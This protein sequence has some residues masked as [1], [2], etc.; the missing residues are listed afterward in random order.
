MQIRIM[1][2]HQTLLETT[3]A[4]EE[5]VRHNS[6]F[7]YSGNVTISGPEENY[8]DTAESSEKQ[9]P[10]LPWDSSPGHHPPDLILH[11]ICELRKR[12][13]SKNYKELETTHS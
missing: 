4:D 12:C 8:I 10:T 3:S 9:I 7:T 13:Q 2:M 1:G 6:L 5:V 11:Y